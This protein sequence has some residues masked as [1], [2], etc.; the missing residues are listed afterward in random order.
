[1]S[2]ED[3]V[4]GIDLGTTYSCVSVYINNKVEV[5][6]NSMGNRTT[7][8]WVSFNEN[9]RLIG[10][11]AKTSSSS[12]PSNTIY[13]IKRLMGRKYSDP[14]VQAEIKNF[15]FKVISADGDRCKVEVQYKNEKKILTPEEISGMILGY[16]KETA[17]AYLGQ[18]VTKA[19][20]TVP[21]YFNDAQRQATK[22]AGAIAGLNVLRIIN[23]PTAAAIAYGLDK[24]ADGKER[25]IVVFDCG[26][27]THDISILSLDSGVFEVKSTCGNAHLGG[28]DFDNRLIDLCIEEY[29]R[30]YKVDLKQVEP[31]RR[32]KI[33]ARLHLACE[34]AKRQLST[35]T[36]AP[37]EVDSLYEGN[38]F[39]YVL[40]RAKFE[41]LCADLFRATIEPLNQAMLD[42][43]ISKSQINEIVLVGGSTRVPKIQELLA[44][45]FG[46]DV[47]KLCK[48]INPDEAVAYGAAVQAAVLSG[49][50]SEA[51]DGL[52]LLDVTPLSLGIETSGNV[53]TVLVPRNTSIPT[54]KSQ[55]FSTYSDNQPAVTIKIYEGERALTKDCNLLGQFELGGIPPMPRGQP[56]IEITYEIDSNGILN[57]NAVEKSTSKTNKITITNDKS[58]LSKEDVERMVAEAEKFKDQDEVN[59]QQIEAKNTLES[60]I[61]S[62]RNTMSEDK[63]KDKFLSDEKETLTEK[64]TE[65]DAWLS[66]SS[67]ATKVDFDSKQ[68]EL[69]TIFNPIMKRLYAE[70]GSSPSDSPPEAPSSGSAS[71]NPPGPGGFDPSQI[72][73]MLKNMPP[74][75]REQIMKQAMSGMG[76][77]PGMGG[78]GGMPG[79][80][81][82]GGM[83]GMDGLGETQ[84]THDTDVLGEID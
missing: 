74:E 52:L 32:K 50:K 25:N 11:A 38:D 66:S 75:Q 40:T 16:M 19:V 51:L 44:D 10:E 39:N 13:D 33:R 24:I 79:M 37:I 17:E 23:E 5:I 29:K 42:A 34:R 64:L 78:M 36:T 54:K 14:I 72:E 20:I 41:S 57:V 8:S 28:E 12:N 27:G 6:A 47:S 49:V 31:E 48:S 43:K 30:K 71:P 58:R 63:F 73:E 81:G 80:G 59:K 56:Q 53:M 76:G 3:Y 15:P 45:Y 69:E 84:E 35:A 55:T 9:E 1:M 46:L 83:P 62:V 4:I 22:D 7:P 68:K 61:Y 77:M 70:T 26:G 60:Y 18:K 2:T 67:S 21:A 65:L 82:M